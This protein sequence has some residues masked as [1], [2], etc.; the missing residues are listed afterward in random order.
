MDA[1]R[2]SPMLRLMPVPKS[3][4]SLALIAI[5]LPCLAFGIVSFF[6][7]GGPTFG[8]LIMGSFGLALLGLY[9]WIVLRSQ[10]TKASPYW[11]FTD[12]GLALHH[13]DGRLLALFEW[14]RFQKVSIKIAPLQILGECQF[15]EIDLG[16]GSVLTIAPE[17][18]LS[19]TD[20]ID[21]ILTYRSDI[22]VVRS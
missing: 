16:S 13:S 12:R 6:T 5:G 8:T 7:S 3:S 14:S 11:Q 2:T 18:K 21:C 15:L 22:L 1:I 19:V 17:G 20:L 10:Q 4:A 9:C